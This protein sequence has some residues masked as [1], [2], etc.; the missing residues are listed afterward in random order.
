MKISR[1][2]KGIRSLNFIHRFHRLHRWVPRKSVKSVVKVRIP[3]SESGL[4]PQITQIS[5]IG[6]REES[7]LICVTNLWLI[8]LCYLATT[9]GLRLWLWSAAACCR[10]GRP[11]LASGM[12]ARVC[13]K[14]A[15]GTRKRKQACALHKTTQ[16]KIVASK[17]ESQIRNRHS[18]FV[19]RHL[20]SDRWATG[21]S[22][23]L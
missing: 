17:S 12:G 18:S 16:C 5:Q 3:N 13:R 20:A 7:A 14:Q 2:V 11:K 8:L 19:N 9:P 22:F 23:V 10:F 4:H 1:Q 6:F 21:L 15:S